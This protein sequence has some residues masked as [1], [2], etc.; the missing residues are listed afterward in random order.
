MDRTH[1]GISAHMAEKAIVGRIES[2]LKGVWDTFSHGGNARFKC[3][4]EW[5]HE[6]GE[7]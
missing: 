1:K 3:A 2:F 5:R 4:Y 7:Y 6:R